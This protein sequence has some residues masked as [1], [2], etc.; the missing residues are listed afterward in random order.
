MDTFIPARPFTHHPG[1][2]SDRKNAQRELEMEILK[3]SIDPPLLPLIRE[4]IP[5]THFF[6]V[7]CCYGHFVHDLEPDTENLVLPSRYLGKVETVTYRLAYLAVCIQDNGRGREFYADLEALAEENPDYFQF[8]SADWFWEGMVN[9]YCIQLE[10]ERFKAKDSAV[11][12]LREALVI[13]ELQK[14]F[15]NRLA[16]IIHRHRAS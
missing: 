16:E 9:T 2:L 15:F 6:T 7:Q 5:I 4:C 8:G 12:S 3:G 10:P 14:V 13:E 1:Y 11:I